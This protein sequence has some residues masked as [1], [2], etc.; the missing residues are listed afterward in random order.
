MIIVSYKCK[1]EGCD[2]WIKIGEMPEDSAR[3]IY[4]P[5]NLG[6]EPQSITCSGCQQTHDYFFAE[7]DMA[8]SAR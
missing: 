8:R 1:T 7:Q 6:D 5:I 4:H 3:T 2:A